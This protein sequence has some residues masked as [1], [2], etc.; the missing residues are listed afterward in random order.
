MTFGSNATH[1]ARE[2]R[3]DRKRH[4]DST[5]SASG[6][7]KVGFL[8]HY[9]PTTKV[10]VFP[11]TKIVDKQKFEEGTNITRVE[12]ADSLKKN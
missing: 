5:T 7:Q 8:F 10:K 6:E 1:D 3:A 2:I 4:S 12:W 11:H 9:V